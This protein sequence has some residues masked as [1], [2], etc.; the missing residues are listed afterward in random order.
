VTAAL[1]DCLFAVNRQQEGLALMKAEYAKNAR[2]EE[3]AMMIQTAVRAKDF[4]LA[5]KE[6]ESLVQKNPK[7]ARYQLQLAEV[8]RLKGD[9]KS[10]LDLLKKAQA[11]DPNGLQTNLQLALMLETDGTPTAATPYYENALRV[12]PEN[13]I[14]L[15]NLAFRLAEENKDLDQALGY[16]QKARQRMPT[17]DD[18]SD[19]LG[20]VYIKKNLPENAI[21]IYRDLLLRSPKNA[22][23]LYHMAEALALKGER[24]KAR[25][26]LQSALATKPPPADEARIR[27]LLSKLS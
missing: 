26:A 27:E 6:L 20:W 19:T 21:L 9:R 3:L 24:V 11:T 8:M 7:D 4:G 25:E 22:T 18:V 14:I 15:N 23:Y 2:P 12:D 10:S 1:T 5:Q 16:A 17:S 13:P